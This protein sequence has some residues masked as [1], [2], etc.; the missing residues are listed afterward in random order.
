MNVDSLYEIDTINLLILKNLLFYVSEFVKKCLSNVNFLFIE[1][2][3]I[4]F[5]YVQYY[6]PHYCQFWCILEGRKEKKILQ[7]C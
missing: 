4:V 6:R 3:Y 7:I 2:E 1:V 5:L